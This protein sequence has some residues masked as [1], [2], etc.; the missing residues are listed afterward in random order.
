MKLQSSIRWT[1]SAALL[2]LPTIVVTAGQAK[3]SETE[4]SLVCNI[5]RDGMLEVRLGKIAETRAT[6]ESVKKFARHMV[7]DHSKANEELKEAAKK[8]QLNYLQ[9]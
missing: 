5:A 3:T 8:T 1:L 4:C 9:I 2:L 7:M 6:S